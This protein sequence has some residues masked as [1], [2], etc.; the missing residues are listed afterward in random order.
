MKGPF[1]VVLIV[2]DTMRA[3]AVYPLETNERM[4]FLREFSKECIVFK[5]AVSP[6]SWTIPAH[7]SIFTGLY[8]SRNGVIE[9]VNGEIPNYSDLFEK[10]EGDTI[11]ENLSKRGYKTIGFSQNLLIAPDTSFSRGFDEFY[12]T[13]NPNQ[14]IYFRM[15]ENY[16][17][18]IKNYGSSFK[19]ILPKINSISKFRKFISLYS[20]L[21]KDTKK[22]NNSDLRDKGGQKVI[23]RIEELNLKEPF[24]IFINLMEMHDP[25]D[26]KSLNLGWADSFFRENQLPLKF[27]EE[28]RKSYHEATKT[29]DEIL[30][31]LINNLKERKILDK[32]ILIITADHGQCLMEKEEFFGH[33]TFLYDELI[34]VPLIIR[35]P[36]GDKFNV[37]DGFQ[38]TSKIKGFI[39]GVLEGYNIFD[40]ITEDFVFSECYGSLDKEIERYSGNKKYREVLEKIDRSRKAIFY[41]DYK[42]VV[43]MK[44]KK[45]EELKK[46]NGEN[47][48]NKTDKIVG[49]MTD[50]IDI[51]SWSG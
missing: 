45:I 3:D 44:D 5:N 4:P 2:L 7:A 40:S 31:R 39:E 14:D 43:D 13:H 23:D 6:A 17:K 47:G 9:R 21:K 12:Y 10:Y 42:L 37:K 48:I 49:E 33:G 8:P 11:S 41:K 20:T 34:K 15:L 1:N 16:N 46:L 35:M 38:S 25:H 32:T 29:T 24:F 18:I 22:L 51:F 27:V 30:S 19:E 50:L 28:V 36:N 26:N